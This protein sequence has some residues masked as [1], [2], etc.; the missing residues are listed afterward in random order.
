MK[1]ALCC[2]I[3]YVGT[4][5][6]LAGCLNDAA[7]WEEALVQRGFEVS[8]LLERDAT[9]AAIMENLARLIERLSY[10]DIL[11]WTFSGHGSWVPD[12]SG[13]EPDGRDEIICPYDITEGIWIT[14]DQITEVFSKKKA[15]ARIIMLSDSCHSGSVSRMSTALAPNPRGQKIRFLPPSAFM[16]ER[17][18]SDVRGF[19]IARASK[20][21]GSSASLLISGCRDREFSYDAW[22]GDRAN[23]AFT[24]AAIDSLEEMHSPASYRDWHKKIRTKL[25]SAEYPQTPQI[26][27]RADMKKWTALGEGR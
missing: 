26:L 3:N 20:P 22:F 6:D 11:V 14:D 9:A 13:D 7:D 8:K 25:P 10:G 24:R 15:G 23:G 19:S 1:L 2:G 27:A 21:V 17:D 4:G 12:D 16:T 18:I 5:S